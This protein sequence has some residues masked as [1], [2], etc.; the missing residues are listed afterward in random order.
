MKSPALN[1]R[2]ELIAE[3]LDSGD[4][5]YRARI[6]QHAN[7][8]P[9]HL[10]GDVEQCVEI[11]HRPFPVADSFEDLG[12]PRS[13]F[14]A[15]SALRAA[16]VSEEASN[17]RDHRHHRLRIIDHDDP[18]GAEHRTLFYKSLVV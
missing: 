6:A 1:Q 9:R 3:L 2:L 11:F 8:F 17:S 5:G 12:R 10:L 15:L 16:L 13:S 4:D 7:G 18:T 14:A